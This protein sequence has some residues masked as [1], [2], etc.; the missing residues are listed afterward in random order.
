M[1]GWAESDQDRG[2]GPKKR[3]NCGDVAGRRDSCRTLN[4]PERK[5]HRFLFFC[6]HL[7]FDGVLRTVTTT[8]N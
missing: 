7:S 4:E 6:Q 3:A 2:L 8:A 1:A 5:K